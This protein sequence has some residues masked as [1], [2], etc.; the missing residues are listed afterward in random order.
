MTTRHSC[1]LFLLLIPSVSLSENIPQVE[2]FSTHKE[3]FISRKID[4]EHSKEV[5]G[6]LV[7]ALINFNASEVSKVLRDYGK[8][9]KLVPFFTKTKITKK[10]RNKAWIYFRAKILKGAMSLDARVKAVETMEPDGVRTFMLKLISG[11]VKS[12]FI[13]FKVT[14][15]SKDKCIIRAMM[16]IDPDIWFVKNSSASNYNLVN[17]RRIIRGIRKQIKLKKSNFA[18]VQ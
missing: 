4:T 9:H 18:Y 14:P 3:N 8:Y 2:E 7:Y 17:A 5:K 12:M 16:L 6:G 11:N 10:E 1:F 13:S 15:V